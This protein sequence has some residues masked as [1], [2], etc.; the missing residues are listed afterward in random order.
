[1][2]SLERDSLAVERAEAV[3]NKWRA[4]GTAVWDA[5]DADFKAYMDTVSNMQHLYD[6]TAGEG[7]ATST[8][9]LH[10]SAKRV[11]LAETPKLEEGLLHILLVHNSPVTPEKVSPWLLAQLA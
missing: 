5:P 9:V 10:E 7:M 8:R 4:E 2:S 3:F 6:K 1:M 11:L